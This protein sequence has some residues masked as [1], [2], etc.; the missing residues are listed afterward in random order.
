MRSSW[1]GAT[2]APMSIALSSG[3]PT[4]NVSM[5][6]F[7]LATK[8]SWMPSWMSSRDPAQQ[9]WPWLNQIASTTPSTALSRS[10]SSKTMK[11]DLPPSS[12]VSDLP[13]PAVASRMRRPTSVEPVKAILSMPGCL[14][15]SSPVVPSP[16]TM[17]TTPG[18][19]PAISQISA[20]RSAVSG[21]N[22]AGFSTT[23]LPSAIAGA[24]FQ[25]SISSGK[26]HGMIWPQTPTG[27]AVGEFAFHQLR[28]AGVIVEVAGDKRD[29]D[30]A[31]LADWLAV[32]EGFEHGKKPAVAL[33]EPRDGVEIARPLVAAAP[34]PG[35]LRL[36]RRLH[37]RIDVGRRRPARPSPEHCRSPDR[38]CR[39]RCRSSAS[40]RC[41]RYRAAC[42][43]CVSSARREPAHRSPAP[44]RSPF[45]RGFRRS[46]C[47]TIAW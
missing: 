23:V 31:G 8:A 18:G 27:L 32:V 43:R 16:V 24:I 33:D 35:L 14:T 36:A 11:G 37:G 34:G 10:A 15:I 42:P 9:T 45:A 41:R 13:E 30:V 47:Q 6:A 3:G 26:F 46:T 19:R 44:G 7:S 40:A 25:A 22:S 20:N 39:T 4:R 21:V 5:R 17:L 28:P 12:R 38:W 2:I 1:I 29:V